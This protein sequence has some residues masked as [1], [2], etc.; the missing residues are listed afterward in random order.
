MEWDRQIPCALNLEAEK[1]TAWV[2]LGLVWVWL[3]QYTKLTTTNDEDRT[4]MN[5]T[6]IMINGLPAAFTEIDRLQAEI[7]R[8]E[9]FKFQ[10]LDALVMPRDSN[11]TN[12]IVRIQELHTQ[13]AMSDIRKGKIEL[14]ENRLKAADEEIISM[15]AKL[16]RSSLNPAAAEF[17]PAATNS[18]REAVI[19][20][21]AEK[22]TTSPCLDAEKPSMTVTE[23][24]E[25]VPDHTKDWPAYKN[26]CVTRIKSLL[27][28]CN[29]PCGF[30]KKCAAIT[31]LLCFCKENAMPF[32]R[33]RI[34]LYSTILAKCWEFL[35]EK[36][37]DELKELL[38]WH[39][40]ESRDIVTHKNWTLCGHMEC[41]SRRSELMT[42]HAQK[43]GP[44]PL[45]LDPS[46][47]VESTVKP[48]VEKMINTNTE[49]PAKAH[50]PN[51]SHGTQYRTRTRTGVISR[52]NYVDM[53]DSEE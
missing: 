48:I 1:L 7:D 31:A 42:E 27:K 51:T 33:S 35:A 40:E 9:R 43:T 4:K 13:V 10:V 18:F 22:K 20:H 37:T 3:R 26:Y 47:T 44:A 39:I 8:L 52:V 49:E 5:K 2:G 24:V 19:K 21:I 29:E 38:I 53:D 25:I 28:P 41:Y 30:E 36:P 6:P 14:L 46:V 15:R 45:I 23:L 11:Y 34:E 32:I 16:Q 17:I 12:M 50:E